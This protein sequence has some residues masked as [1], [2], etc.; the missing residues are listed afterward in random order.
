M[1][2]PFTSEAGFPK[3]AFLALSVL[4]FANLAYAQDTNS[5]NKVRSI[6]S[7]WF[8]DFADLN[9]D[10]IKDMVGVNG[11]S[12]SDINIYH[13]KSDGTFELQSTLPGSGEYYAIYLHKLNADNMADIVAVSNISGIIYLSSPT[14]YVA[15]DLPSSGTFND[16]ATL[17]SDFNNDGVLDVFIK[18]Q[19]L[20]NNNNGTFTSASSIPGNGG[21]VVTNF[22]NDNF[23]DIVI[24]NPGSGVVYFYKGNGD[25]TF[26]SPIYK[27]LTVYGVIAHDLN[28]DGFVDMIFQGYDG[29]VVVLY[30]DASFS[31]SQSLSFNLGHN[32]ATT[33]N[34]FDIDHDGTLDL[35]TSNDNDVQYRP[36]LQDG[37]F[38]SEETFEIGMGSL[39]ELFYRDVIGEDFPDMVVM[40]GSGTTR[41][42]SDKLNATL[43]FIATEKVYDAQAMTNFYEVTPPDVVTKVNYTGFANAP[44]DAGSYD[45]TINSED[46]DYES[47]P[48]SG[49]ISIAKKTLI[50]DAV[51]VSIM[52]TEPIPSF[53]LSYTG[54]AGSEDESVLAQQPSA[55]V[56]ATPESEPGHYEITISDGVDENYAFEYQTGVLTIKDFVVGIPEDLMTGVFP[57]PATDK[58]NITYPQWK[59]ARIYD[60]TGR[61]IIERNYSNEAISLA[62]CEPGTYILFVHL[63]DGTRLQRKVLL[64]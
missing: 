23:Q 64:Y 40:S 25:G 7:P 11:N 24:T 54:F 33:L 53:T 17:F 37:S 44:K 35:V 52:Q 5:F 58:I 45:V 18:G 27:T 51:D 6:S 26:E 63:N 3:L 19:T 49:S 50:V 57:N 29:D 2:F 1:R 41:I 36:I 9:G 21:A 38:G 12:N 22:N 15:A 34:I 55:S 32:Y 8:V 62:G 56:T 60:V 48:L 4:F 39:R 47:A 43:Q 31:F 61:M 59:Y 20:I 14:G 42:Y 10:N 46:P 28:A 30:N 16:L 13:G